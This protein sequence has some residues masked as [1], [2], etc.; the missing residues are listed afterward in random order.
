MKLF[1]FLFVRDDR[2]MMMLEDQTTNG[3]N[4]VSP[5]SHHPMFFTHQS[6][7]MNPGGGSERLKFQSYRSSPYNYSQTQRKSSPNDGNIYIHFLL[8][9]LLTVKKKFF[10][11][12]KHTN[13]LFR[14]DH[15]FE[16]FFSFSNKT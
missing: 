8:F 3:N 4:Y 16:I 2:D 13:V 14:N 7:P 15:T 10:S 1:F 12:K 5:F 11:S 6:S 9:T